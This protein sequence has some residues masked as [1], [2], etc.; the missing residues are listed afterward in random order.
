MSNSKLVFKMK[1][2]DS[3]GN[4]DT[5][6]KKVIHNGAVLSD[7]LVEVKYFLQSCGWV[8]NGDIE[9]VEYVEDIIESDIF[10]DDENFID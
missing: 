7:V 5:I 1:T 10:N 2:R 6:T 8:I 4:V 9:V 3:Y